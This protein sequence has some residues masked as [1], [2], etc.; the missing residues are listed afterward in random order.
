[1]KICITA[2]NCFIGYP[3]VKKASDLGWEVIAVVREGNKKK[4]DI[5]SI[6]NVNVVEL[7]LED[8]NII[9]EKIGPV[10]CAVL[11]TWN[12]TR[13]QTRM[14]EKLQE[15]NYK[16]NMEAVKSLVMNGCKRILTAGSQAEYGL[17]NEMI[18]EETPCRPNTAYGK[19]KLMLFNNSYGYCKKNG[20]TFIEPRFF[21]L[22]GPGDYEN[23]MI[24]SSVRNMVEN[25]LCEFTKA[26]QMWDYLY[27]DDAVEAL[28]LL[29]EKDCADGAYNLGSGDSRP[30]KAYIEEQKNYLKSNSELRFGAIPYGDAGVV[31]IFP[32]IHKLTSETGWKP[33]ISFEDGLKRIVDTLPFE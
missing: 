2:A 21:S 31:S 3:L 18:M 23:T 16:Y 8:Y 32:C 4:E 24:M 14:D 30:L 11:L 6:A 19:Y 22:Y 29:C 17:Y 12:G 13:G 26:I 33:K 27:I 9:G 10:D 28:A 25:K 5:E 15:S 1:M 20:V 7:N